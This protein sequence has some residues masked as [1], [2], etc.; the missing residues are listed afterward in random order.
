M[1]EQ[2]LA[3][4]ANLVWS[5]PPSLTLLVYPRFPQKHIQVLPVGTITE[6]VKV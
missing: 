1:G 2:A 6:L 4:V 3:D 5:W